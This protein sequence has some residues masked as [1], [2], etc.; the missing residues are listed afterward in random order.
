L[1]FSDASADQIT[2]FESIAEAEGYVREGVM[3]QPTGASR[4]YRLFDEARAVGFGFDFVEEGQDAPL[5]LQR[6]K[7]TSEVRRKLEGLG[8]FVLTELTGFCPVQA[9]GEIDGQYFYFRARGSFWH[10]ELGGNSIGTK[11]PRW[12]HE[13]Y[14]PGK[15]DVDAGYLSDQDAVSC[16]L[17]SDEIF[18]TKDVGKFDKSH[19]GYERTI[20]EGWAMGAL[21]L[22]RAVRR[23]GVGGDE[24]IRRAVESGIELPYGAD[25]ELKSLSTRPNTVFALDKVTGRWINMRDEDEDDDPVE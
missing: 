2:N 12:W 16:I 23:L 10:I 25:L 11:G 14:W 1:E 17:K 21:S 24:A 6:L 4:L 13:E 22:R 20:L 7:L 3:W 8:N 19:P 18:R 9:E 5:D 15:T